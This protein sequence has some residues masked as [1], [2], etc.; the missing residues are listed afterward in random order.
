MLEQCQ[1]HNLDSVYMLHALMHLKRIRYAS[2][3][4][5]TFAKHVGHYACFVE[6]SSSIEDNFSTV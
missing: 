6:K 4:D 5:F 1:D 3:P 2:D